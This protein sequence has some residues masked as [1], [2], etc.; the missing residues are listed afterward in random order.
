MFVHWRFTV[1]NGTRPHHRY[2]FY[3][4]ALRFWGLHREFFERSRLSFPPREEFVA[5]AV[6]LSYLRVPDPMVR[7]RSRFRLD[8]SSRQMSGLPIGDQHPVSVCRGI[9]RYPLW[10]NF[11]GI[12]RTTPVVAMVAL[13][14]VVARVV[15]DLRSSCHMFDCI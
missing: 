2:V 12:R 14:L 7:Q 15:V 8:P 5:S 1:P 9:L 11:F 4:L 13:R 10:R 3:S 6:A